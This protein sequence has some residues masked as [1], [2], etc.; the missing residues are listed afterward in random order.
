M[1][2]NFSFV[3]FFILNTYMVDIYKQLRQTFD[4]SDMDRLHLEVL[5]EIYN[6]FSFD[7][8]LQ[9][10]ATENTVQKDIIFH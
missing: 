1:Y 8:I 2:I 5:L 3:L 7:M 4:A 6:D 9:H 10:V